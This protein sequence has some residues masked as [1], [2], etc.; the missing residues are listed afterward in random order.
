VPLEALPASFRED[1]E[2]HLAWAACQDPFAPEARSRPLAPN[3]IRLRREQVRTAVTALVAAGTSLAS[4]TSLGALV[5]PA[6]FKSIWRQRQTR[7]HRGGSNVSDQDLAKALVAIAREWVKP[8]SEEL[9]DLKGLLARTPK[10]RPGLTQKNTALLARFD[11]PEVLRRLIALP[12]QLIEEAEREPP[13]ERSL[14]K[15]QAAVAISIQLHAGL[16]PSNLA[17]L[18]F[19]ETL[20]LADRDNRES[21]IELP[22]DLVKNGEPFGSAL[23][24]EATALLRRYRDNVLKPFLGRTPTFVFDT[25]KG[26]PKLAPTLSWLVQRTIKRRLGFHMVLHQFRHLDGKILLEEHPGAHESVREFLG[27]KNMKTTINFYA[28]LDRR[29]AVRLHAQVLRKIAEENAEPAVGVR[30]RRKSRN[31]PLLKRGRRHD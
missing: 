1:L 27:H 30:K 9:K 3:S 11:D 26:K 5:T 15:A 29:R 25:G 14:A 16:R 28:G 6:A 12:K 4:I 24:P 18:R 31:S 22:P 13:S 23:A 10:T 7:P 8:D 17:A 21:L 20:M 2:A 19:G